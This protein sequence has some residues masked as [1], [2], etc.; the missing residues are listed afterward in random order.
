MNN[1]NPYNTLRLAC[2]A[3]KEKETED[4][5]DKIF[6]SL[7]LLIDS[8]DNKKLPYSG[9]SLVVNRR[10]RKMPHYRRVETTNFRKSISLV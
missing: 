3:E 2:Y 8:L 4:R 9:L 1:E 5:I 10:A 6:R 7:G